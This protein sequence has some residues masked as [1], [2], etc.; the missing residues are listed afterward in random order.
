MSNTD[1]SNVGTK[2]HLESLS[3]DQLRTLQTMLQSLG[4]Y[5]DGSVD[6]IYGPK[7]QR[8]WKEWKEDNFL[9]QHKHIGP[10]SVRTITN[11]YRK[12]M[13]TKLVVPPNFQPETRNQLVSAVIRVA[14]SMGLTYDAQHAYILATIEHETA[15][16][17]EPVREAYWLS[18]EWRAQ[19][20]RYYP[21]YGRGYVQLTW[22]SNYQKYSNLLG[23]DLVKQP[24]KV[25]EAGI[26]LYILVHGFKHGTFTNHKLEDYIGGE[27]I[28]YIGARKVINGLDKANHIA[29]LASKWYGRLTSPN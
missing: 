22:R 15:S 27:K 23:I 29:N 25:L 17:F 12:V 16:T 19:N 13:D 26:A 18:E 11:Q 9:N 7:T 5:Q 4:Y 2:I 6:G 10:A 20:L 28:D 14:N 8:A 21:Y 1:L 24:D 3:S